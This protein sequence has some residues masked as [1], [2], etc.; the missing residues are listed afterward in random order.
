MIGRP[1]R[2]HDIGP[3]EG[4]RGDDDRQHLGAWEALILS[5]WCGLVAGL[6]EVAVILL[7]KAVFDYNQLYWMS[8]HFLWLIPVVTTAIFA[9]VGLAMSLAVT[10]FRERGAIVGTRLLAALTLLPALWAAAPRIYG[11]AG[12]LLALGAGWRIVPFLESREIGVRR[13]VRLTLPIA[14]ATV[15]LTA[16]S[17]WGSDRLRAWREA[18]RALPAPGSPNVLLIVMDTVRADHLSLHGYTRPTSPTLEELAARGFRFDHVQATSSWTLM[19]HATMF[20]GKWPHELSANWFTPLDR[21]YPTLAEYASSLGYATAGFVANNW[22]CASDSGLGRGFTTYRDYVFPRLTA[23]KSTVLV[24]R[25]IDGIQSVERGLEDWLDFDLLRP[26]T[27][28]LG[29]LFKSNRKDAGTVNSEFLDWLSRRQTPERP[30]FAFLNYYDAHYPYE[31]PVGGSRRFAAKARTG[32]EVTLMRDWPQLMQKGPT[33]SQIAHGRDAYDD[34]IADLDEQ[35][36]QLIDE[37]ERRSILQ[38]TWVIITSDHGES[39]GENHGVFWHGTSLYQ[40]QLHVPLLIVP[41]ASAGPFAPQVFDQTVSLRDLATTIVDLLEIKT[42]SPFTGNTLARFWSRPA[43]KSDSD[44][45]VSHSPALAEVVPLD[46]FG[47]DPSE[48]R[49]KKR[50]PLAAL[51]EG[52]WTYIKRGGEPNEEL[53]RL[54]EDRAESQ[55]VAGDPSML[56]IL[57]RMRK[58]LERL[59]AGP[60]TPERFNP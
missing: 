6:L 36:G 24:D 39:F 49:T 47:S 21:T 13:I 37:L 10:F 1:A 5:L 25:T 27:D 33:E 30:F 7:R 18:G 38:A 3:S 55:N 45:A 19:S 41:P 32:S 42:G 17:E 31:L 8:R 29:W 60:L 22:Y 51:S 15:A 34:C 23:F 46:S 59:T 26:A 35:I 11:L 12:F 20:T 44:H 48:W 9:V 54:R 58:A 40:A 14:A 2:G 52:D 56:P 43:S 16:A 50:W 57:E 28:R 4:S 53:Y